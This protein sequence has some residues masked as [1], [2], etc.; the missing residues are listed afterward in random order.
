MPL[1]DCVFVFDPGGIVMISSCAVWRPASFWISVLSSFHSV[2]AML[3]V[4]QWISQRKDMELQAVREAYGVYALYSF[5]EGSLVKG[6]SFATCVG[7]G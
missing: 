5:I 1:Q 6:V 7:L 2:L 4:E 3:T